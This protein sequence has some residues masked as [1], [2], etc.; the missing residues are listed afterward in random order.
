VM[1]A[2]YS[3]NTLVLGSNTY[4]FNTEV[5]L[6]SYA[7]KSAVALYGSTDAMDL[8]GMRF[9]PTRVI[10]LLFYGTASILL[11]GLLLLFWRTRLGLALRGA[12]SNDKAVRALGANVPLLLVTALAI[13]NGLAALSGALFVQELSVVDQ[14]DG[15]G[16]IVGGLACVMIG[17]AFFSR[18][19][20]VMRFIGA[21]IGALIYRLLIALLVSVDST[22]GDVKLF[23][24][25]FVIAAL[26]LPR[27]LR[28]LRLS[29]AITPGTE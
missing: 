23:T 10:S 20:F 2:L 4:N 28:R 11:C 29:R 12:G 25:L 5:T 21:M 9:L 27:T 17:D 8:V 22:S 7:E 24:A 15:V 3:V 16:M 14:K 26:V 19:G 18:R 1:T 6:L 13:S